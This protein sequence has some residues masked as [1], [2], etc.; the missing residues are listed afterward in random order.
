MSPCAAGRSFSGFVGGHV[1]NR[2]K[3]AVLFSHQELLNNPELMTDSEQFHQVWEQ[4]YGESSLPLLTPEGEQ[5]HSLESGKPLLF[6]T[7]GCFFWNS[8]FS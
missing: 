3:V 4:L 8:V 5:E 1:E 7:A 6:L 2:R